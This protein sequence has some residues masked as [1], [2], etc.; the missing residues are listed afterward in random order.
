M[1]KALVQKNC[2]NLS[3]CHALFVDTMNSNKKR[4]SNL[5]RHN[6]LPM[7]NNEKSLDLCTHL[8]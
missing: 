5:R 3:S 7:S 8:Q 4:N 6:V 1:E 2:R